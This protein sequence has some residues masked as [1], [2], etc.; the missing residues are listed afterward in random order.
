M[1]IRSICINAVKKS[2][3]FYAYAIIVHTLD[4]QLLQQLLIEQFDTFPVQCR[5]IEHMH[6]G[7]WLRKNNF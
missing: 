2:V 1:F 6:E 5:L 3:G 7:V 4:D